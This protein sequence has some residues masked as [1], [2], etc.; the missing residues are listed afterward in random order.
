MYYVP[1]QQLQQMHNGQP[2]IQNPEVAHINHMSWPVSKPIQQHERIHISFN[3]DHGN[4]AQPMSTRATVSEFP[5][6]QRRPLA[7]V[8]PFIM[9]NLAS[10]KPLQTPPAINEDILYS[11]KV[12]AQLQG[13]YEIETS[14]G[15]VQVT[16]ILPEVGEH[17]EQYAKVQLVSTHENALA[18]KFIYNELCNFKLCSANNMIEGILRK[19]SNMKHSVQWWNPENQTYTV[20]R[21]KGDVTFNLVQVGANSRRNSLSSVCT[22]ST[23]PIMPYHPIDA[24]TIDSDGST[25]GIRSELLQQRLPISL[26]HSSGGHFSQAV[27]LQSNP[28]NTFVRE[29]VPK[30]DQPRDEIFE[31]IKS[32]CLKNKLLLKKVLA[33]GIANDPERQISQD[34]TKY[35][36][37]GRFWIIAH[38]KD[39]AQKEA[40]VD[41]LDDIKGAYQQTSTGVYMQPDPKECGSGVQH[42]LSKDQQGCWMLERQDLGC[43]GWQLRAR[44]EKNEWWIDFK[45]NRTPIRV[46]IIP[47]RSI[48]EKMGEEHI[49]NQNE[50]KKSL[51]FLF[52]SCNQEKLTRLK[53]RNLK[54]HIANLKVKL[55]KR[56]ALSFGVR[57]ANT[58]ET[59]AQE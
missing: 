15:I 18:E 25:M 46:Y 23:C 52:T 10:P 54:H 16:V 42:R 6:Q 50:I 29:S 30:S 19:G 31:L 2:G 28:N 14:D 20:W 38:S 59:I 43:E 36:S 37:E 47:M 33:W 58:A 22:L 34:R 12:L 5:Y 48:L 27:N 1:A 8:S 56:H 32:Q 57:I 9:G 39:I 7:D 3:R 13:S 24:T 41:I 26:N 53:G 35:L 17:Q 45:H 40:S 4:L 55:E 49:E 44:Q 51:D 11:C 21:R